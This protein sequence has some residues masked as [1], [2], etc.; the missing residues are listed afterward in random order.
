M[1]ELRLG[2]RAISRASITTMDI[3]RLGRLEGCHRMYVE[4]MRT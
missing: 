3:T 1:D 4:R 2:R